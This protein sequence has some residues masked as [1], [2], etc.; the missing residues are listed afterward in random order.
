MSIARLL[1]TMSANGGM[2]FS[3]NFVV[4][5][6]NPPV[7]PPGTGADYFEMFC[8]EAQLPNTNTAQGEINGSYVGSGQVKYPHSR[9]FTEFQLGF[10]CD[11]NM[12]SLKFLQD[13]LDFIFNEEGSNV[14]RKTLREIQSL[15]TSSLRPE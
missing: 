15:S 4:K 8:N 12:S 7:E 5:F 9:I 2:S 6:N 13:W 10:L 1:T 11:A 14:N 3:N